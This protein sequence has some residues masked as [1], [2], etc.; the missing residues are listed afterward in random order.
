[1]NT[2]EGWRRTVFSGIPASD[3]KT[4]TVSSKA[5]LVPLTFDDRAE[6]KR[7][8]RDPL[9]VSVEVHQKP[10]TLQPGFVTYEGP[11]GSTPVQP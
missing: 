8:A 7:L 6:L 1:M 4:N 5:N 9:R 3:A 11:L 2:S 10:G